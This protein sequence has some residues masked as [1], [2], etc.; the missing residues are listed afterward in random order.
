M[1]DTPP[2]NG[3]QTSADDFFATA[4]I[5]SE[6]RERSAASGLIAVSGRF[7]QIALRLVAIAT[8]ARLL[9]P[10]D[11]GVRALVLPVIILT[12]SVINLRL[13]VAALQHEDLDSE[14]LGRVFRLS[15]RFNL[16]IVL[17]VAALGPLLGEIY[18]D[19]R[20]VGV[21]A[22]WAAAIYIL[23][24]GAFH[25]ALLKRQMRF[26]VTTLIETLAM[27]IGMI[28]AILAASLGAG[29][30]ALVLEIAVIGL[31]RSSGAWIACPWRPPPR[32]H[33]GPDERVTE[34]LRFGRNLAGFQILQWVGSQ[35]DR[36]LVGLLGGAHVAG[37][38]DGARR[39]GW[40]PTVELDGAITEV[41]VSSF[42]RAQEQQATLRRLVR[43][44]ISATLF[45]SLPV[46][47]FLFLETEGAVR[48]LFGDRWLG[49]VPF[50][51]YMCFG[52]FF[53]A[54]SRPTSWIFTSL[55]RTRRQFRWGLFQT[56]VI[57][58]T[59]LV[60]SISG[61]R[62]IAAGYAAA[63]TF[64]AFPTIW[65][66]LRGTAIRLRDYLSAALRP[67]IAAIVAGF[68][69]VG[70]VGLFGDIGTPARMTVE[71]AVFTTSY[72]LVWVAQP[73]GPAAARDGWALLIELAR[74]AGARLRGTGAPAEASV[75]GD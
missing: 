38:Y 1:N 49:A 39:W 42:S 23:N 11:F 9:T 14:G 27:F 48:I 56:A 43:G 30:W 19:T 62:G 71:F 74:G 58:G 12:N 60:G 29:Y 16:L 18:N 61:P 13:N 46:T 40:L 63:H 36:V 44:A 20:V 17:I 21:T 37:L 32:T 33:T 66:C 75:T 54:I 28:V 26:G 6:L 10:G 3:S 22:A 25:E 8:L 35:T 64:L 24:L 15:L 70:T 2:D 69:A 67:A 7:I 51:K 52:A 65:F 41:A 4:G 53:S 34:M 55:G 72:L 68:A 45:L 47:A 57:F 5:S 73:G 31:V 59:L 50:L